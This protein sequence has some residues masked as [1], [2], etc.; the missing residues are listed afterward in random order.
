MK[1]LLSEV[2]V[3]KDKLRIPRPPELAAAGCFC[4]PGLKREKGKT[5][6]PE[7]YEVRGMGTT[8]IR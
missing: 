4:H 2:Q 3:V 8:T 1:E 7:P 5:M 6:L